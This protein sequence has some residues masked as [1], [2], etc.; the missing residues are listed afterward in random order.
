MSDRLTAKLRMYKRLL[1]TLRK[2]AA[3]WQAVPAFARAVAA[4]ETEI[5][6]IEALN[7]SLQADNT[8]TTEDKVTSKEHMIERALHISGILVAYAHDIQSAELAQDAAVTKSDFKAIK[9]MDNDDLA[10]HIY[11]LGVK[12][13]AQAS[14]YGMN[15][16]DLNEFAQHIETFSERI[17]QPKELLTNTKQ[18]RGQQQR[19]FDKADQVIQ[20]IMDNLV[21]Q[22]KKKDLAFYQ[23]YEE[24]R[25]VVRT[26]GKP[27]AEV[28]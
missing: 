19:H 3:S 6:A 23:A 18:T 26:S 15:Q 9:E 5:Q 4:L 8:G 27:V 22:F 14:D 13:L 25:S 1:A 12:Y 7:P 24:A 20:N 2:F 10:L 11:E 17:G 16:E 28:A 21:F